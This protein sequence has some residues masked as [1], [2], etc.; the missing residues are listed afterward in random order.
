MNYT[1]HQP[2]GTASTPSLDQKIDSLEGTVSRIQITTSKSN[3]TQLPTPST[4]ASTKK[5]R[6]QLPRANSTSSLNSTQS[7]STPARSLTTASK[8]VKKTLASALTIPILKNTSPEDWDVDQVA[9]W[10]G[11]MG[12]ES[13]AANFKSK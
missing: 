6:D 1:S 4:S 13:I 5:S 10:L 2:H 7:H 9:A 12:F 11:A 8:N 3:L